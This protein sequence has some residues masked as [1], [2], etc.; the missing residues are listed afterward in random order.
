MLQDEDMRSRS[1]SPQGRSRSPAR[2]SRS[3]RERTYL[4]YI[5]NPDSRSSPNR[6]EEKDEADPNQ[7]NN[8]F[9]TGIAPACADVELRE[10]FEKFGAVD[11][12]AIMRDPHTRDSRGF[13]FV[14]FCEVTHAENAKESLTGTEFLGKVLKID[15]AKRAGARKATPG[16]YRGPVKPREC[17]YLAYLIV[18]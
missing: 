3:P 8:L 12:C 4:F 16:I 18:F 5:F 2:R 6:E 10:L 17:I 14:N 15:T 1:R 11:R 13:A 7:G 9:I